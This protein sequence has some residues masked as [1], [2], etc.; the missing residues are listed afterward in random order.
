MIRLRNKK[1]GAVVNVSED[2]ARRLGPEWEKPT[3]ER[4]KKADEKSDS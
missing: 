1:T 3:K 2:K 4:T